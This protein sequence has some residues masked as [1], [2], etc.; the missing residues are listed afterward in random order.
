M[1]NEA[2]L[3]SI[4]KFENRLNNKFENTVNILSTTT[5]ISQNLK[6]LLVL[7]P[8]KKYKI[9]LKFFACFNLI[10]DITTENNE[11][12]YKL[13]DASEW[14]ILRLEPGVYRI[15]DVNEAIQE[16]IPDNKIKIIPHA[17][18]GRVVLK[19]SPGVRQSRLDMT[20]L[21]SIC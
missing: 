10:D 18:S 19:L 16:V 2:I 3:L 7:D 1:T 4:E 17:P 13:S 15:K 14:E 6:T 12:R 8:S 5:Y 21:L 20:R 9:A 11:L